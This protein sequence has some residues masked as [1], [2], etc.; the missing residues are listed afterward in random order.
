ME[1]IYIWK[2]IFEMDIQSKNLLEIY[3]NNLKQYVMDNNVDVDVFEDIKYR[4]EEKLHKILEKKQKIEE[5]DI[6]QLIEQLWKPHEIFEWQ[7]KWI[8]ITFPKIW[9]IYK[10]SKNWKILWVCYW[11]AQAINVPALYVRIWF[12]VMWLFLQWIAIVIYIVLAILMPENKSN[13]VAEIVDNQDPDFLTRLFNWV[14]WLIQKVLK[15][16]E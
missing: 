2:T 7:K 14:K 3:I 13:K 6:N 15:A 8:N 5:N 4:I 9:K 11:I 12:I 16:L 1:K 10:D